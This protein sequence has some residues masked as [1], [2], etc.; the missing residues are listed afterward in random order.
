MNPVIEEVLLSHKSLYED[1]FKKTNFTNYYACFEYLFYEGNSGRAT[2]KHLRIGNKFVLPFKYRN[3][4]S[5]SGYMP[6]GECTPEEWETIREMFTEIYTNT[7]L[8]LDGVQPENIDIL[9]KSFA[10]KDITKFP[11]PVLSTE[12]VS[13]IQGRH[14]RGIRTAVNK[15]SKNPNIN[16]KDFT[17]DL[18][19][20]AITV[21]RQWQ[22]IIKEKKVESNVNTTD[23]RG[24]I[25]NYDKIQETTSSFYGQIVYDGHNP[26]AFY[27]GVI[28]PV[29]K[30]TA[31][32]YVGYANE[33]YKGINDFSYYL[34]ANYLLKKGIKYMNVGMSGDRKS[35]EAY[36]DK[37]LPVGYEYEHLVR[38]L[39]E[40]N[41]DT[42]EWF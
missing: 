22:K 41:R 32:S 12:V 14:F 36:K 15:F 8:L 9:K 34:E 21:I 6:I 7:Y 16:I 31:F 29:E 39:N 25:L 10:I 37:F 24:I 30:D 33:E 23:I 42:T 35:L 38:V 40:G 26:I 28:S 17:Q 27:L 20:D 11:V 13:K 2:L 3:E 5:I 4:N 19:D 1:L 18:L